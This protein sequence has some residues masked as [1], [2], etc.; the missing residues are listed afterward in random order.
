MFWIPMSAIMAYWHMPAE[1]DWIN[2]IPITPD[3]LK[4]WWHNDY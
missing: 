3:E 1:F 2:L 4:D